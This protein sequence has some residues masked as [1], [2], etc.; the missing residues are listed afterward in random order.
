M[1]G[2]RHMEWVETLYEKYSD[3]VFRTAVIYL[4]S[5]QE[6]YDIVQE[7]FLKLLRH[8]KL[9][10]PKLRQSIPPHPGM[11]QDEAH[12]KAWLLRVAINCCKDQLKSS[13]RKKRV[14]W[15]D[16]KDGSGSA[17]QKW[18]EQSADTERKHTLLSAI[19][20]LP[21]MYREVIYL[22]Y[23]EEYTAEEIGRLIGKNPSTVRSRLQKARELLKKE[24]KG[25]WI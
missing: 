17:V 18:E 12:E 25:E 20:N 1:I 19:H 22:F 7:V 15:D 6:A 10:R 9:P 16:Y 5:E 24:L 8:I 11:F 13:W 23:Y 2:D 4:K 14:S 3:A 21:E